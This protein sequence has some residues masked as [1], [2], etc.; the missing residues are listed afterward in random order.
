MALTTDDKV[1]LS[2]FIIVFS[3]FTTI[4]ITQPILPAIG[5]NFEASPF[6]SSLSVSL[7]LAGITLGSIPSGILS[8]K[9]PISYLV[10]V[11]SALLILCDVICA[12]TPNL[13][14]LVTSRFLQGF[15]IPFLT[16]AIAASLSKTVREGNIVRGI[17]WYVTATILG[18]MCGR[19]IGGV[20]NSMDYWQASFLF[21]GSLIL[22]SCLYIRHLVPESRYC[23]SDEKNRVTYCEIFLERKIWVSLVCAFFGQG[24]FSAVFNTLP[25]R[26]D[27]SQYNLSS[28][29][30]SAIYCVYIVGLIVGPLAGYFTV[31]FGSRRTLSA[32][33]VILFISIWILKGQDLFLII[34]GLGG[35]CIGFFTI[36]TTATA[37]LNRQIDRGLGQANSLYMI[38]YYLGAFCGSIWAILLFEL[39]GW[40]T[41]MHISLCLTLVLLMA[42]RCGKPPTR[43]IDSRL[44]D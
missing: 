25:F 34:I 44:L 8:E 13:F 14:V 19:V 42:G 36:H 35:V 21:S 9:Y 5:R 12:F 40:N 16:S 23:K 22:F 28:D 7:V 30:I 6:Q 32:G 29:I 37:M 15:L 11:G 31:N 43:Q 20:A 41:V 17:A 1:I 10:Y 38:F 27:S 24:I 3:A 2:S 33:T 39:T 26:L 18:G 4:Y